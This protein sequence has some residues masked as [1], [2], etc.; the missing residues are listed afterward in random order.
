MENIYIELNN[1]KLTLKGGLQY[2]IP[3]QN[4]TIGFN[5][6][7]SKATDN[8]AISQDDPGYKAK[9]SIKYGF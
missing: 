7:Y 8:L 1:N 2:K 5:A 4:I 3:A 9:L 6:D